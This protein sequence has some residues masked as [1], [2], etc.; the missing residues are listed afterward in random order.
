M[1]RRSVLLIVAVLIALVGT[2]LIVVYVQGIDARA[3]EGQELVEVLTATDVIDTGETVSD[4][5]GERQVRE[6]AGP[7]RGRGRRRA[8]DT[9]LDHRPGRPRHDLPRRA[10]DRQELRHCWATPRAWSSPTTSMAVSVELSDPERVAG[11]RQPWLRRS[12]SSSPADPVRSPPRR[13]GKDAAVLHAA[14][15]AR[16][17]GDRRRHH[18]RHVQDHDRRDGESTTEEVPKTILTVAVDQKRGGEADLRRAQRR[19]WPS[20]C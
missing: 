12:R 10:A 5:S 16:G 19:S 13:H 17:P 9:T 1:A 4:R 20:L 6:E 8:L 14:P 2:A 18:E 15:P 7:P 11:L 3:T